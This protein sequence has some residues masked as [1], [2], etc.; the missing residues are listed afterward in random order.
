MQFFIGGISID[1]TLLCLSQKHRRATISNQRT[2]ISFFLS[3]FFANLRPVRFGSLAMSISNIFFFAC[4]DLFGLT[5]L[6]G[7]FLA[8]WLLPHL[9][10]TA[11]SRSLTAVLAP[12]QEALCILW[13]LSS[14]LLSS[15]QRW[16]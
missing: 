5:L 8:G 15:S 3:K 4:Q 9:S 13:H 7:I 10:E 1:L 16:A 14:S 2:P 6:F 12:L 11:P